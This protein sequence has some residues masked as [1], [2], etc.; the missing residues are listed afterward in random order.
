MPRF[1]QIFEQAPA[2]ILDYGFDWD[3]F[4]DEGEIIVDSVLAADPPIEITNV[5][6]TETLVIFHAGGGS[7]GRKY[8]ITNTV[9]TNRGRRDKDGIELR[10]R[11]P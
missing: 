2:S 5:T 4:L 7:D 11:E 6:V 9:T 10:V 1:D 3:G 8:R